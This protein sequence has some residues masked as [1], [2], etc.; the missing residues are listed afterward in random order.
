MNHDASLEGGVS[1]HPSLGAHGAVLSPTG[2]AAVSS[3]ERSRRISEYRLP[4]FILLLCTLTSVAACA[5][6]PYRPPS[7]DTVLIHLP[8]SARIAAR[9]GPSSPTSTNSTP[10]TSLEDALARARAF[11]AA[12]R[13]DGDPRLLSYAQ[14]QL[15]PWWNLPHPPTAVRLER[16]RMAQSFHR[17]SEAQRDLDECLR[18]DPRSTEAWILKANVHLVRGEYS[19]ARRACFQLA[20]FADPLTAA[21]VTTSLRGLESAELNVT[22]SLREL[23]EQ[24]TSSPDEL[25]AWAWTSLGEIEA[26]FSDPEAAERSLRTA[27]ELEPGDVYT[28]ATLSDFLLDRQ[29]PAEVLPLVQSNS[30][31]ALLLRSAEAS[32]RL[33][34]DAP[35]TR[36]R[37]AELVEGFAIDEWRGERLHLRE[38]AR[39]VLRLE[40]NP[41]RALTLARENFVLQKEPADARLLIEAAIAA[42]VVDPNDA[43]LAWIRE[44]Q[45]AI[46]LS[47]APPHLARPLAQATPRS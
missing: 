10:E 14:Q 7:D 36:R 38:Q 5:G 1:S 39:F 22:R 23:L 4:G 13:R 42:G 47:F 6:T 12:A 31:P 9:D 8:P 25:R 45:P 16:A 15:R 28:L 46:W 33:S 30:S 41:V 11:A 32:A 27:L 34:P 26:R 21:A 24:S 17:F 44:H 3:S 29:R 37:I 35:D 43:D 19:A 18:E 40:H 20:R 2:S